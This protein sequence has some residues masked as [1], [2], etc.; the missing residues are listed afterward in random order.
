MD[1]P[2]GNNYKVSVTGF[3]LVL[4][5]CA[6]HSADLATS[7]GFFP[8]GAC[9]TTFPPL[10]GGTTTRALLRATYE[11]TASRSFVL[12]PL[13][14]EVPRSEQGGEL[15]SHAR[16]GGCTVLSYWRRSRPPQP[17]QPQAVSNFRTL[18]ASALSNFGPAGAVKPFCA[19]C[20]Q[21]AQNP[22]LPLLTNFQ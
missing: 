19:A 4:Q 20:L 12:P 13:A 17:S 1:C 22:R 9:G 11:I 10:C 3:P 6:E 16:Q 21:D 5:I 8:F 14:G 2:L 15:F 18:R 7:G